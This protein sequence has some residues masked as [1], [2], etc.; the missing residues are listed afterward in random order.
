MKIIEAMVNIDKNVVTLQGAFGER[1]E[2]NMNEQKVLPK[3]AEDELNK[4]H[5][6]SQVG[7][8]MIFQ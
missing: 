8:C 7:D 6:V 2:F 4:L 5:F 1:F 3:W